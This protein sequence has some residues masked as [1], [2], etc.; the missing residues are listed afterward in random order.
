MYEKKNLLFA[1][2]FSFFLFLN[3]VFTNFFFVCLS[4]GVSLYLVLFFAAWVGVA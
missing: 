2:F 4:M 1:S 3:G